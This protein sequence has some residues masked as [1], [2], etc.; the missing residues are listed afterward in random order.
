MYQIPPVV[1]AISPVFV[2]SSFPLVAG[3]VVL[4]IMVVPEGELMQVGQI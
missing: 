1:G 4:A 3:L 2:Y